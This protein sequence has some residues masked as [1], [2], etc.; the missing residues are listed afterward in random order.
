M[1]K[2]VLLE[3]IF[4]GEFFVYDDEL[5]LIS[6]D[7]ETNVRVSDGKIR[8]FFIDDVKVIHVTGK[9]LKERL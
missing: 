5:Y 8:K 3:F 6:E 7:E 2:K 9:H 4:P 1:E